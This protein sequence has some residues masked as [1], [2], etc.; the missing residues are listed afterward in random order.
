LPEED[1]WKGVV[2]CSAG[3][4]CG[5]ERDSRDALSDVS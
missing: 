1:K 4:S 2:T 3:T 5:L